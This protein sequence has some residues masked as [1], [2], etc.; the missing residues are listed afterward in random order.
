MSCK[1]SCKNNQPRHVCRLNCCADCRYEYLANLRYT[2]V[3]LFYKLL[4]AH[5]QVHLLPTLTN[6]SSSIPMSTLFDPLFYCCNCSPL[7]GKPVNNSPTFMS[8][9][10]VYISACMIRVTSTRFFNDI[11]L[12]TWKLQS[13][14]M[15]LEFSVL[16]T[17]VS[18]VPHLKIPHS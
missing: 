12:M 17:R 1:N 5:I 14:Q 4:M 16:V 10:R 18:M 8:I 15:V 9:L 13:S 6:C 7:L 2:N 3:H 11:L